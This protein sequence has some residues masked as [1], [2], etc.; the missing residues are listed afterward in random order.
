MTQT[1]NTQ[2]AQGK[3]QEQADY[4]TVVRLLQITRDRLNAVTIG[5]TELEALLSIEREKTASLQTQL[6]ALTKKD[7]PTGSK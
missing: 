1:S 2:N 5:N 7:T 6:D 4:A 3:G